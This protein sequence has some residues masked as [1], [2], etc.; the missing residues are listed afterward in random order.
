MQKQMPK[1]EPRPLGTGKLRPVGGESLGGLWMGPESRFGNP[2]SSLGSSASGENHRSHVWP[3]GFHASWEQSF[4]PP[5][6]PFRGG[7]HG[8]HFM[9]VPREGSR[10]C[11]LLPPSSILGQP[12]KP[13]RS[14]FPWGIAAGAPESHLTAQAFLRCC[15]Q[16]PGNPG[17]LA[18]RA[19]PRLLRAHC[20][21][22]QNGNP[23]TPPP[24]HSCPGP[25]AGQ[26]F[27]HH[28]GQESIWRTKSTL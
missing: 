25:Q 7:G 6:C 5:V 21:H 20:S 1:A 19:Q 10:S 2:A 16:H 13:Q 9:A 4:P 3:S 27:Q 18:S 15:C 14:G 28:Q 23:Q 17:P 11:R 8:A 12:R 22:L 26:K 24:L